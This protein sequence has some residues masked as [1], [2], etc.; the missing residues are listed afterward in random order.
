MSF[1]VCEVTG[2]LDEQIEQ[3]WFCLWVWRMQCFECRLLRLEFLLIKA[4]KD[5]L[6]WKQ[7]SVFGLPG[8]ESF[9]FYYYCKPNPNL[10]LV[11]TNLQL[12]SD[13]PQASTSE[14]YAQ[15]KYWNFL[16]KSHTFEICTKLIFFLKNEKRSVQLSWSGRAF[17][18][19]FCIWTF[20]ADSLYRHYNLLIFKLVSTT[21]LHNR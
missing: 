1:Q 21:M 7:G 3:V 16:D 14:S 15:K 2:R 13:V 11:E 19:A 20:V 10:L 4:E 18:P 8:G 17:F 12:S 5:I 6:V 9:V